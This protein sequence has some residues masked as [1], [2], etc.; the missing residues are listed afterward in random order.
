MTSAGRIQI[1]HVLDR[2]VILDAKADA[3][4][5][6][7]QHA[8]VAVVIPVVIYVNLPS[9]VG[10]LDHHVELHVRQPVRVAAIIPAPV[11]VVMA[12]SGNACRDALAT[13]AVNAR[14][15][16]CQP[17]NRRAVMDIAKEK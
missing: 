4:V 2:H 12:A 17:A 14:R 7:I 8:K 6:V 1:I 10:V 3:K 5:G 9:M 16:V 11:V 13:A 15:A